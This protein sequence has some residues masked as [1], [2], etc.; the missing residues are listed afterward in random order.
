[1]I[2]H[3]R[4]ISFHQTQEML[5]GIFLLN[6]CFWVCFLSLPN[7]LPSS[8]GFSTL[9]GLT[10]PSTSSTW[11]QGPKVI[12][13][14]GS[15]KLHI[16]Q[17]WRK[18][19]WKVLRFHPISRP[20]PIYL[21]RI[22]YK[23][24]LNVAVLVGNCTGNAEG[25]KIACAWAISSS[26]TLWGTG[27]RMSSVCMVEIIKCFQINE[28]EKQHIK[29]LPDPEKSWEHGEEAGNTR[30][31]TTLGTYYLFKKK[32]LITLCVPS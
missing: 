13:K 12:C 11:E 30:T 28:A 24:N 23:V 3:F 10:L 31:F 5:P 17:C 8:M 26:L 1:M 29:A 7:T 20:V 16:I 32:N 19:V 25:Q 4:T 6:W 9:G 2:L 18:N 22:S 21:V 14:N 27:L 15:L